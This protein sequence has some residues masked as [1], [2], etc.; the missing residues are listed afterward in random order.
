MLQKSAYLLL[1]YNIAIIVISQYAIMRI[2]IKGYNSM[3]I[4]DMEPRDIDEVLSVADS[5][6]FDEELYKWTIPSDNERTD[7]IKTFFQYRLKNAFGEKVMQ[8]AVDDIGEIA[9]A[10]VWVPPIKEENNGGKSSDFEG[11][12]SRF[13]NDIRERCYKFVS[14]VT[15]AE[16]HFT[17]PYWVLA[18]VFVNK[19]M[20]GKGIASLLIRNQLINIDE[21]HLPCILV[22][23]EINN[24]S[25]Y[26][27][28]GFKVV[29]EVP[30]G[31]SGLI[32][33]G[34]LRK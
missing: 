25:I 24:I 13:S 16:S 19:E 17:Q 32:S 14:T 4:R 6:F 34:M 1:L 10:A 2:Q 28:Y 5:A 26:E 23:Q 9:G 7:F 18:P 12:I 33:Y 11:M 8:V 22:T 30:I 20:Q 27:K 31:E 21:T 29:V 15:E 3:T